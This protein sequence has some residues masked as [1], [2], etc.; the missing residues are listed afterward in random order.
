M[1]NVYSV[2]AVNA[3]TVP[4]ATPAQVHVVAHGVVTTSGWTSPALVPR[5]GGAPVDGFLDFDLTATPPAG[6]SLDVLTETEA[7]LTVAAVPGLEGVRVYGR[8]NML[9]S[10]ISDAGVPETPPSMP[11]PAPF[12]WPHPFPPSSYPRY[13]EVIYSSLLPE[14]GPWWPPKPGREVPPLRPFPLGTDALGGVRGGEGR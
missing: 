5:N 11:E 7:S 3:Q 4:G 9:S 2:S 12:P 10:P 1:T 8:T 6:L 13:E 14:H